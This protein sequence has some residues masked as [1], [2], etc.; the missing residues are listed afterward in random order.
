MGHQGGASCGVLQWP[1]DFD[2]VSV[3]G[4]DICYPVGFQV[5][6][7]V[8]CIL[9]HIHN[10]IYEMIIAILEP[11]I[12]LPTM[13][14]NGAFNWLVW[15][16][17]TNPD[18]WG[19]LV[20]MGPTSF[21]WGVVIPLSIILLLV[22]TSL[23]A[24]RAG[25][26]S[27]YEAKR[28]FRRLGI[29]F[30]TIFFWLPIASTGMK[31]FDEMAWF[32]VTGGP[33]GGAPGNAILSIGSTLAPPLV[34][35][36]AL[37]AA[38]GLIAGAVSAGVSL[39]ALAP[40]ILLVV[41]LL[42]IP[43]FVM[44][45]WIIFRT[46]IIVTLTMAMPIIAVFWAVDVFPFNG[47]SR[48]ASKAGGAYPGLLVSGIPPAFVYRLLYEVDSWGF[49]SFL[50]A[51]LVLGAFP[52]IIYIQIVTIKWAAG[53]AAEANMAQKMGQKVQR[54]GRQ[55]SRV[56]RKVNSSRASKTDVEP[57][58]ER[59]VLEA[60]SGIEVS[61]WLTDGD[62]VVHEGPDAEAVHETFGVG[63]ARRLDEVDA[64][65]VTLASVKALASADDETGAAVAD[66]Q[67]EVEDSAARVEALTDESRRVREHSE[68]LS[69]RV[70]DLEQRLDAVTADSPTTDDDESDQ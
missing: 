19:D 43:I 58:D 11:I 2:C 50:S 44:F 33:G 42:I 55:V 39:A 24:L 22:A 23:V 25:T 70:D 63:R 69:A 27:R 3:L 9:R 28:Q 40:V 48:L 32:I 7:D 13:N 51:V 45:A 15:T 5:P 36:T 26:L 46:I 67:R 18:I 38:G 34:T 21:Y 59:S 54:G 49:A 66:L 14:G 1:L 37:F 68:R 57:V 62:A 61:R 47:F 35:G 52:L 29:A 10:I 4:S 30:L 41:T 17:A 12:G 64:Y 60:V 56:G 20:Y 6:I 65:G 53:T 8:H 31:F 16:E